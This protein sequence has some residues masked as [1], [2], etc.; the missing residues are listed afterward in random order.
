M[1]SA[2][3]S[4]PTRSRR[5]QRLHG[6]RCRS[7]MLAVVPRMFGGNGWPV[8]TSRISPHV[9]NSC[10]NSCQCHARCQAACLYA[11]CSP[12]FSVC[13]VTQW[14]VR[15]P[16]GRW[17]PRTKL[18][19]TAQDRMTHGYVGPGG[20]CCLLVYRHAR[21]PTCRDIQADTKRMKKTTT[22]AHGHR[23]RVAPDPAR[24]GA[25]RPIAVLAVEP[26]DPPGA[27]QNAEVCPHAPRKPPK[28][29]IR[30]TGAG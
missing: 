20:R 28:A 12:L 14:P 22:A 15:C 10:P 4:S 1:P 6:Q 11:I 5:A 25:S 26:S 13:A 24:R 16:V 19:Y 8:K 18:R 27:R 29:C 3:N 2:G 9:L 30:Q 7:L 17:L 21:R 23:C